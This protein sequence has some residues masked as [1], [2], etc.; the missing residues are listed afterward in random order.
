[1]LVLSAAAFGALPA[2]RASRLDAGQEHVATAAARVQTFTL[3]SNPIDIRYGQVIGYGPGGDFFNT[4]GRG[5]EVYPLPKEV[6]ERYADGSRHMAITGYESAI[7]RRHA[8]GSETDVPLWEVY[9]HHAGVHIAGATPADSAGI[10][11]DN[12]QRCRSPTRFDAPFRLLLDRPTEYFFHYHFIKTWPKGQPFTYTVS[13]LH[14]CPCTPQNEPDV[15]TMGD[16]SSAPALLAENNPVCS[17]ETYTGGA[18]C[19]NQLLASRRP[20]FVI[21]TDKLCAD[22]ECTDLPVERFFLKATIHYEDAMPSMRSLNRAPRTGDHL[23]PNIECTAMVNEYV[24]PQCAEGT[25]SS[26]CVHVHSCVR[27]FLLNVSGGEWDPL[28]RGLDVHQARPHMH[29]GAISIELQDART[30]T[31]LCLLSRSNGGLVV[32]EG[33]AAGDEYGYLVASPACVWGAEDA[34]RIVPGQLLRM[35]GIYD[36]TQRQNGVMAQWLLHVAEAR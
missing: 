34:P 2:L 30:N 25:P 28:P 4:S 21:D 3:Y 32:G 6:R 1:M 17:R 19:C 18:L 15:S 20:Y 35:I 10:N 33:E 11:L 36:A 9:N 29:A 23:A 16:C 5:P 8:D 31:T 13:P 14:Q 12:L 22:A 24:A 26:K 27:P 7:V